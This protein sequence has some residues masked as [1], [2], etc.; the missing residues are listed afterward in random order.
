VR[1]SDGPRSTVGPDRVAAQ[2]GFRGGRGAGR[3][4]TT[5]VQEWTRVVIA[6]CERTGLTRSDRDR[7]G[8]QRGTRVGRKREKGPESAVFHRSRSRRGRRCLL[9]CGGGLKVSSPHVHDVVYRCPPDPT[10]EARDGDRNLY[11]GKHV[12]S[13]RHPKQ[14]G[15]ELFS[16]HGT[17]TKVETNHGPAKTG[18]P[19]AAVRV[20]RM[21]DGRR[22]RHSPRLRKPKLD[23]P[24]Q[25]ARL[26]RPS[27][28]GCGFS[29]EC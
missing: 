14:L 16:Q 2:G 26:M 1:P 11:V 15:R 27:R 25:P 7:A 22:R 8:A 10:P 20:R 28:D 21:S 12:V 18:P 19:R 13:R 23:G 29:V 6:W 24:P 3:G 5:A 17:V 4:L 9:S